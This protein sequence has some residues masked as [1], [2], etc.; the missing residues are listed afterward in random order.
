MLEHLAGDHRVEGL[1]GER[2][3]HG[4]VGVHVADVGPR[5]RRTGRAQGLAAEIEAD[6]EETGPRLGW[7][8][9]VLSREPVEDAADAVFE[10]EEMFW[11]N[12]EERLEAARGE[13]R[14]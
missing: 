10:G 9:W 13:G 12:E 6:D 4:G 11:V 3:R 5:D 8:T 1:V 2:K 7:N 14:A